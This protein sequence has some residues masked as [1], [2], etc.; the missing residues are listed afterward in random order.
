[1]KFL[2]TKKNNSGFKEYNFNTILTIFAVVCFAGVFAFV[3]F[4]VSELVNDNK[5][6]I[7]S[8]DIMKLKEGK[9]RWNNLLFGG[10]QEFNT[11][12]NFQI[13]FL[14]KKLIEEMLKFLENC[15]YDLVAICIKIK[16]R[17]TII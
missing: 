14:I 1:M 8:V 4:G 7:T 9:Y 3:G 6:K 5:L 16:T 15:K 10:L 12:E 13:K 2:Y 17:N 11:Y